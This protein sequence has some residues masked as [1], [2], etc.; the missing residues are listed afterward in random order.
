M[1]SVYASVL[2]VFF[3]AL[4]FAIGCVIWTVVGWCLGDAFS[5]APIT[6]ALTGLAWQVGC[7]F[8]YHD[9]MWSAVQRSHQRFELLL[10]RVFA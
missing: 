6:G 4:G 10:Q 7:Y 1:I 8:W 9:Q 5:H 2:A 3:H